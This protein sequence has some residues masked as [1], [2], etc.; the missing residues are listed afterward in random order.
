MREAIGPDQA[1]TH[2][3][4]RGD[5]IMIAPWILHRHHSLWNN[6]DTFD[7]DRFMPDMPQ[8]PRFSYMPFGAGPRICVG[9]QFALAEATIVLAAFAE[10]FAWALEDSRP[11]LPIGIVTTQPDHHPMFRLRLR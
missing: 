7:P 5:L 8:P 9:M 3:I 10:R 4:A 2:K 11:V 6:P 1:G